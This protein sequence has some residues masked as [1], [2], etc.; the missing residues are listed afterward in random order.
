MRKKRVPH[1]IKK[2]NP[3][4]PMTVD[5]ETPKKSEVRHAKGHM[6]FIEEIEEDKLSIF[7]QGVQ[8]EINSRLE[9]IPFQ[10]DLSDTLATYR[11][12]ILF[13]LADLIA[14]LDESA[15]KNFFEAVKF[16]LV[17][18][19]PCV[20]KTS[21]REEFHEDRQ[22]EFDKFIKLA[23]PFIYSVDCDCE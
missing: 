23:V 15:Q 20:H 6:V 17:R 18:Y 5:V 10:I 2:V 9:N 16:R 1:N 14:G 11:F 22:K 13:Y 3:L 21:I 8:D 12:P 4:P 7:T 19:V